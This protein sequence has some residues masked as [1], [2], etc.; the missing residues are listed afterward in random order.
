MTESEDSFNRGT[1]LALLQPKQLRFQ[2]SR[3]RKTS[4]LF[5]FFLSLV[6]CFYKILFCLFQTYP[7]CTVTSTFKTELGFTF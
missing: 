1:T 2:T 5:P 6:Q 3:G 7:L 4:H